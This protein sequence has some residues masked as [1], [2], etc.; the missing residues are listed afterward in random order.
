MVA[1]TLDARDKQV[2]ISSVMRT[3]HITP[4]I[5]TSARFDTGTDTPGFI[6]TAHNIQNSRTDRNRWLARVS[7]SPY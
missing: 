1:T 6:D 5:I 7:D 4:G 3:D 2:D